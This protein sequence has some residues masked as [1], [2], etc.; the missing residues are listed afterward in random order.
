[1]GCNT[2][3]LTLAASTASAAV[4]V[5]TAPV[6]GQANTDEVVA[7]QSTISAADA[8]AL[9]E[10]MTSQ[11]FL[12]AEIRRLTELK[13]QE[14]A[15]QPRRRGPAQQGA[16]RGGGSGG[17]DCATAEPVVL[18]VGGMNEDIVLSGDTS[19]AVDDL[20]DIP[21]CDYGISGAPDLVY[22]WTPDTDGIL[23]AST[24]SDA[25]YDTKLYIYENTCGDDDAI[26][27]CDDDTGGCAGF[28]SQIA[29]VSVTAGNQYYIVV[30]GWNA[31]SSGTFN[32]TLG[33]ANPAGAADTCEEANDIFAAG[34]VD[35]W[36]FPLTITGST[37]A[38]NDDYNEVCPYTTTGAPDV[39][40]TFETGAAG[41]FPETISIDLCQGNTNYDSK[42]YVWKFSC[43]GSVVGCNDDA[44]TSASGQPFVSQIP[45][46]EL[47]SNSTYFVVVDGWSGADLGTFFMTI[48]DATPPPPAPTCSGSSGAPFSAAVDST[49]GV[50]F[51]LSE[52]E[53]GF[54]Q[55]S[56]LDLS[57]A[58]SISEMRWWGT[59]LELDPTTGLL[60]PTASCD[61]S[62]STYDVVIFDDLFGAP[63]AE[64]CRYSGVSPVV[65]GTEFFPLAAFENLEIIQYDLDLAGMTNE[66]TGE[67]GCQTL[68]GWVAITGNAEAVGLEPVCAFLWA[69]SALRDTEVGSL[70]ISGGAVT[71]SQ[72]IL[73]FCGL[74]FA[75]N[76]G[77]Q[78]GACCSES[79]GFPFDDGPCEDGFIATD[80]QNLFA[81]EA[82]PFVACDEI[83]CFVTQGACCI[84]DTGDANEF[85][86]LGV[87]SVDDCDSMAA[88]LGVDPADFEWKPENGCFECDVA[89]PAGDN[90]GNAI[91][92]TDGS[93]TLFSTVG[94]TLE[95]GE[96]A[97][98]SCTGGTG[99]NSVWASFT[100]P[101]GEA[102]LVTFDT[103][104]SALDTILTAWD[105]CP[106]DDGAELACN[107]DSCGL[108]SEIQ[109]IVEPGETVL[110]RGT[111]W[112]DAQGP[113]VLNVTSEAIPPAA[114]CTDSGCVIV[115]SPSECDALS[116]AYRLGIGDCADA[117]CNDTCETADSTSLAGISATPT[118]LNVTTGAGVEDG[119]F[120]DSS[121]WVSSGGN[122]AAWYTFVAPCDGDFSAVTT[123]AIDTEMLLFDVTE[124]CPVAGE[125]TQIAEGCDDQCVAGGFSACIQD[126]PLVAGNTYALRV[127]AF[128]AGTLSGAPVDV[129]IQGV[130]C[131][132]G[133]VDC[134]GD[135]TGD[136][137]VGLADLLAVLSAWG[138]TDADADVDDSGLVGLGDL[139]AVLSAWGTSCE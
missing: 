99:N 78:T 39:V 38:A 70:T 108:Q 18:G 139:L 35:P 24:C 52:P 26:V 118:T 64:R 73:S 71:E 21:D 125:L 36:E 106:G 32:L 48:D 121:C 10:K 135:A 53:F 58:T 31:G 107:D 97:S 105:A 44:C 8:Q 60:D 50:G 91:V 92:V 131:G 2:R 128:G 117:H 67:V 15:N 11:E 86:C 102:L 16:M 17:E 136:L 23:S 133:G 98:V 62:A 113:F 5:C 94:A 109:V 111:G 101:A 76:P 3:D 47:D 54:T 46:I 13:R 115:D 80:C 74:G 28:T 134:P 126:I 37:A 20:N 57:N 45:S 103:C 4:L 104:G 82:F 127:A 27:G 1:M 63:G 112:N 129:D 95:D 137:T 116:G 90:C 122:Q 132:G 55:V 96:S 65:T 59:N 84:G 93:T 75:L 81:G 33:Y 89:P 19:G 12:D 40:Y 9:K 43:E 61:G 138:T 120:A 14:L 51:R 69:T 88:G 30:D 100:A 41:T 114:C 110:I 85:Q 124:G 83:E 130:D 119:F 77:Q 79:T 34:G 56:K 87:M 42:V 66:A 7:K 25:A 72:D 49:A 68:G 29:G 6:L 22:V 123:A